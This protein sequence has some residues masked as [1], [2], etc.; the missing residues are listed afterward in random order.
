MVFCG[1]QRAG[2]DSQVYYL[3]PGAHT[4]DISCTRCAILPLK[5]P[6]F[7]VNSFNVLGHR[8]QTIKAC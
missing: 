6:S 4:Q 2:I 3:D 1:G 7:E 5:R 8:G